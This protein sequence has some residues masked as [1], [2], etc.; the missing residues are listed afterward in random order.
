MVNLGFF[1]LAEDD[2]PTV[3]D[4]PYPSVQITYDEMRDEDDRTI[5]R[6]DSITGAWTRTADGLTY[7]DIVITGGS[8]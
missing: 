7:S 4:G 1:S 6:F 5:A 2:L 8:L 3:T